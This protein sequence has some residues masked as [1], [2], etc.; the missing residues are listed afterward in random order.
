MNLL[1]LIKFIIFSWCFDFTCTVHP[2]K[3]KKTTTSCKRRVK[4]AL[5]STG[6]LQA[7]L[8]LRKTRGTAGWYS[9]L[10]TI[11]NEQVFCF[12]LSSY[13][14]LSQEN[15]VMLIKR[16]KKISKGAVLTSTKGWKPKC[17]DLNVDT[18]AIWIFTFHKISG[19]VRVI[20][21]ANLNKPTGQ[22][23][24]FFFWKFIYIILNFLLFLQE[25]SNSL[26]FTHYCCYFKKIDMF[27]SL[28]FPSNCN[29]NMSH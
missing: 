4:G 1:N 25:L 27:E 29:S 14:F 2:P 22:D 19:F 12:L 23:Y 11:L 7:K 20:L 15:F 26:L 28:F 13:S 17:I 10:K 16:K 24:D 18:V 6:D 3:V 5:G 8:D 9:G 21:K